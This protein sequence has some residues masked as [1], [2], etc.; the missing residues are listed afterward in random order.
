MPANVQQKTHIG[1]KRQR[2]LHVRGC[3]DNAGINAQAGFQHVFA[4]AGRHGVSDVNHVGPAVFAGK[5]GVHVTQ[6]FG[7]GFQDVAVIFLAVSPDELPV[8]V[9]NGNFYRS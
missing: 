1:R 6:K 5:I 2:P 7:C 4:V 8:F 9:H 3:F